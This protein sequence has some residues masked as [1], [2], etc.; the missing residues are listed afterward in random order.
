MAHAQPLPTPSVLRPAP[1]L[2]ELLER[3][4]AFHVDLAVEFIGTGALLAGRIVAVPGTFLQDVQSGTPLP[5]AL[6]GAL[7]EFADVEL[8]AGS[9]LVGYVADYANFQDRFLADLISLPLTFAAAVAQTTGEI[10]HPG[11]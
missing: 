8:D 6:G 4:V 9:K 10:V 2:D 5:V 7:R 11:A 1:R 3:Q